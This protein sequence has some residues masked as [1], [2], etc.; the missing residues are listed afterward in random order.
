[1]ISAVNLVFIIITG[2]ILLTFMVS[3]F[4]LYKEI[5]RLNSELAYYKIKYLWKAG[6]LFK[7]GNYNLTS[8]DGGKIWY[9]CRI[10]TIDTTPWHYETDEIKILGAA[11]EIY[12]GLLSELKGMNALIEY[13]RKNGPLLDGE[14]ASKY[15]QLLK[16]AGFEIS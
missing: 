11:E 8:L 15:I 3:A 10:T 6:Y 4:P 16:E 12:P 9:A 5:K 1:M 7:Y 14:R 2:F 13:V